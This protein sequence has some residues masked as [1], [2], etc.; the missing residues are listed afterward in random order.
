[1]ESEKLEKTHDVT[2]LNKF[3]KYTRF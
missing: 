3:K 2:L 1:M